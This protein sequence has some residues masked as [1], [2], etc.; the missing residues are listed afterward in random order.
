MTACP[1]G[2]TRSSATIDCSR[3]TSK[4]RCPTCDRS[5]GENGGFFLRRARL[6]FTARVSDRINVSIQP[7]FASELGGRENSLVLRHYYAD[8]YF[9]SAKTFRA[10]IGQSEV[11][12]G[13]EALQSSSRA[14]SFRSCGCNG[15]RRAR[16][17]G[18]RRIPHVGAAWPEAAP[19][20]SRHE[21]AQGHERLRYHHRRR[22]QRTGRK[23]RGGE[24]CTARHRARGVSVSRAK[25]GH[26]GRRVR[27][28][29]DVYDRASAA[30]AGRRRRRRLRRPES[31][32]RV[33]PVSTAVRSAGRV[34]RRTR[35]R[36]RRADELDRRP[37]RSRRIRDGLVFARAARD[38]AA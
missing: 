7:E 18:P 3:R 31:G 35:T 21:R 14:Q 2:V 23:P 24:R 13:F 20:R 10:R 6:I 27:L 1:S 5:I 29:R 25:T 36:V 28:H 22:V 9:D 26:R 30:C 19:A 32:R 12:T 4:L 17:A 33:H 34:E 38:T 15:E 37:T 16:R 8:I 11:P